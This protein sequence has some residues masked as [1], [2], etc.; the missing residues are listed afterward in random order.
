MLLVAWNRPTLIFK[1]FSFFL[2]K[3]KNFKNLNGSSVLRTKI[4]HLAKVFDKWPF[5]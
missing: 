4:Y 5:W 2:A 1:I 3:N